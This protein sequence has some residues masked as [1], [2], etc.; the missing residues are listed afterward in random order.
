MK[1]LALLLFVAVVTSSTAFCQPGFQKHNPLLDLNLSP[2]HN[3][4]INPEFN[5]GINPKFNWNLNPMHNDAL[6]PIKNQTINPQSNPALNPKLCEV[7]NPMFANALH[8][9]NPVWHGTFLFDKEDKLIGYISMACQQILL[10]FN[11]GG[12]WTGYYVKSS[13]NTY[14]EFTVEG[15]WTGKYLCPDLNEGY[16]L[17]TNEGDWTGNH[18]K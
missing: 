13:F 15:V 4:K 14:N 2:S 11:T 8:P 1:K 10:S 17:F 3:Q 18:I 9:K 7:L 12:D 6:N 5:S 16:N